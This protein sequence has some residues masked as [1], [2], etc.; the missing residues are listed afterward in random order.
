M[1]P[2]N[3]SR[4]V[5]VIGGAG[6]VGLPLALTF[7][8]AGF[9]TVIYDTN[10]AA[11]AG[12]AAGR[13]PFFESGGP[14]LLASVLQAG[15]LE[16]DPTP[17][18]LA[19]CEFVVVVIGTPVDEHL[20]PNLSS[21]RVALDRCRGSLRDG[22]V[23]ILRSTVVPGMSA[24]LQRHLRDLGLDIGVAFC[25]ERVAQGHSLEEFA[26]LPQIISAFD[27]TT[28]ARVRKLFGPFT[29]EFIEVPP[30]EAELTKLMTNAWRYIQFATVNQFYMLATNEGL[31]FDRIL[32]AC[33]HNYPRMKGIP[34]PGLAAGPCLM[35]DTMQLAA[36]SQNAFVLGHAAM[37]VNEGLPAHLVGL[38]RQQLDLAGATAG[39]LGMAFKAESDDPRDSL[40]YKLRKLLQLEAREVLCTDPYVRDAALLPVEEVILKSDVLFVAAPHRSY[41]SLPLPEGKVLVDIWN[42]LGSEVAAQ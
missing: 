33:R 8:N 35:K 7:A 2:S 15:T 19:E 24:H 21:I 17:S 20:N 3:F 12:I 5:C 42:C 16:L 27:E 32:H 14:E 36:F 22:Q 38:A 29:R 31:D 23:L 34:G 11:L 25:P 18:L 1:S 28:L 13:M 30:K 26:T 6:H 41:R 37:L 40:S 9:R 10:E 4:H 39:I